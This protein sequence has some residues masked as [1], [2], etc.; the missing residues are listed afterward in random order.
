[1]V[2]APN[3]LSSTTLRPRGP[4]VTL[5]ASAS[6]LTPSSSR[7]RVSSEKLRI[8]AMYVPSG[9]TAPSPALPGPGRCQLFSRSLLDDREDVAGGE[10]QV[11]LA[12]VL[13]LGAAVLRV[14]DRVADVDV[15]RNP[16]ALVV[17][18]ARADSEDGALLRLLL[19]GVGDHDA[20]RRGGL[21]L[22]RLDQDPV[23]ERLDRNLGRGSH[24]HTLLGYI[25]L[26]PSA[27]GRADDLPHATGRCRRRGCRS[28]WQATN[29][30]PPVGVHQPT[31]AGWL[32]TLGSRVLTADYVAS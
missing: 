17:D 29:R 13:D 1:M 18:A 2:G 4:R 9:G 31:S 26:K 12:G 28:A 3:F 19:G 11:L 5:T 32:G 6:A 20:R 14:D 27:N 22:I 30:R 24:G 16:V 10:H 7:C 21:S 23:L 15:N 8:F 25:V